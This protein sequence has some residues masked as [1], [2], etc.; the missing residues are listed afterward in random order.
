MNG[1]SDGRRRCR[2]AIAAV[3]LLCVL[4]IPLIAHAQLP[5]RH[6]ELGAYL[7]RYDVCGLDQ[8]EGMVNWKW[9]RDAEGAAHLDA[10]AVNLDYLGI[11]W[12]GRPDWF[13][14]EFEDYATWLRDNTAGPVMLHPRP[15]HRLDWMPAPGPMPGDRVEF[16]AP[17]QCA[18][19]ED[20]SKRYGDYVAQAT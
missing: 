16:Y 9:M 7:H 17:R 18:I 13:E 3:F 2:D 11:P 19:P 5:T 15:M 4:C 6:Y 1:F 10:V 8:P 20:A 12:D 14:Q